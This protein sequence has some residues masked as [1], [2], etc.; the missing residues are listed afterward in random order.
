VLLI[1]HDFQVVLADRKK[2]VFF[3]VEIQIDSA[4]AQAEPL[5]NVFHPGPV[6]ATL[7]KLSMAAWIIFSLR[8]DLYWPVTLGII[9]T[10]LQ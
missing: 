8:S 1:P 5:G 3:A 9:L 10:P 6:K 2:E 4:L 7:G